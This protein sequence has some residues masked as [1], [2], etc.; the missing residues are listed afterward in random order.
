MVSIAFGLRNL[1]NYELGIMVMA[2]ML[3]TGGYAAILEFSPPRNSLFFKLY[4]FY[5]A[6]VLPRVGALFSGLNSEYQYLSSSI[7]GFL[8]PEDILKIMRAAGLKNL[9]CKRLFGGIAYLFTG[10]K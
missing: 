2:R 9:N 4:K 7:R 6:R 8:S 1:N 10:Q 5:L 3:K